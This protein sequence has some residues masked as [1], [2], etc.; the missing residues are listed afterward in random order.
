MSTLDVGTMPDGRFIV[1]RIDKD[2][3]V[4]ERW[5][6]K[7]GGWVKGWQNLG[8]PGNGAAAIKVARMKDGR[9]EVFALDRNGDPFHIYHRRE[10]GWVGA[11]AGKRVAAWQSLK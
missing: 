1:F 10:G 4:L 2:G 3:N 8:R 9:Q 7:E 5:H 11:E 6:A